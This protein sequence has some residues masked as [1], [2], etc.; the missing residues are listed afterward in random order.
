MKDVIKVLFSLFAVAVVAYVLTSSWS[1]RRIGEA[2]VKNYAIMVRKSV[3]YDQA[4]G[5][6]GLAH[7]AT[8]QIGVTKMVFESQFAQT[9][10]GMQQT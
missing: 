8:G 7:I 1:G 9:C 6:A 2:H 5:Q 3:A 4:H 10:G